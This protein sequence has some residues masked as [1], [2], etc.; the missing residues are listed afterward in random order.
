M[1]DSNLKEHSKNGERTVGAVD[2]LLADSVGWHLRR[3]H[4][5]S[6]R[7]LLAL[8]AVFKCAGGFPSGS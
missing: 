1:V 8:N 2:P 3:H 5:L 7:D 6:H 4:S